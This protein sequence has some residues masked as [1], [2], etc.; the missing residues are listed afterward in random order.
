MTQRQLA[1][2]CGWGDAQGRV[3]NYERGER[4]RLADTDLRALAAA[5]QCTPEWLQ[6][7]AEAPDLS[8]EEWHLVQLYRALGLAERRSL[9]FTMQRVSEAPPARYG[10]A[11]DHGTPEWDLPIGE[12]PAGGHRERADRDL[13]RPQRDEKHGQ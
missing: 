4:E 1:E 9:H 5:L 12:E 13:Q 3:G 10:A 11:G 8:A 6:W 2:A 7:G